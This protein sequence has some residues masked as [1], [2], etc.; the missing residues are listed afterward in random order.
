MNTSLEDLTSFLLVSR[1]MSVSTINYN[2]TWIY[3]KL[4]I[5]HLFR[6]DVSKPTYL[7]MLIKC[8]EQFVLFKR[9]SFASGISGGD[10][11]EDLQSLL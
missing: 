11:E 6:Y 3:I 2:F 10:L 5:F 9:F 7:S 1:A 8:Q 4:Q